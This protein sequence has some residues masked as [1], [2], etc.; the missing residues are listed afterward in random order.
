[1]TESALTPAQALAARKLLRWGRIAL[2]W[3]MGISVTPIERFEK[4]SIAARAFDPRKAREIF[5]SAGVEFI[6]ENGG[7]PGV[8][9]R[10]ATR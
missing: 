9:L 10:K 4:G 2:A 1:M 7:G 5:E 8:R 3:R 6:A